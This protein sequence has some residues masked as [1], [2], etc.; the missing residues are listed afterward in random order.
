MMACYGM[1]WI[2]R[3]AR[4]E[5]LDPALMKR[6]NPRSVLLLA[7]LKVSQAPRL[8][9]ILQQIKNNAHQISSCLE[10]GLAVSSP[11]HVSW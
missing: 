1:S 4:L 5:F 8:T 6:L 11:L 7:S 10:I 2:E 9:E 3:R